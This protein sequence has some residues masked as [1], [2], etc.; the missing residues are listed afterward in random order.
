M[1]TV[2]VAVTPALHRVDVLGLGLGLGLAGGVVINVLDQLL[3]GDAHLP[4][5]SLDE[6]RRLAG[7][8][9]LDVPTQSLWTSI[10]MFLPPATAANRPDVEFGPRSGSGIEIG[11]GSNGHAPVRLTG[12]CLGRDLRKVP[13][14]RIPKTHQSRSRILKNAGL[15]HEVA[16]AEGVAAV[17]GAAAAAAD[18]ALAAGAVVVEGAGADEQHSRMHVYLG[19]SGVKDRAKT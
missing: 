19:T 2:L 9:V 7:V 13:P 4:D 14:K 3:Q 6:D 16:A 10:A 12:T 15:A 17:A 1:I 18:E 5:Q 8:L 11:I